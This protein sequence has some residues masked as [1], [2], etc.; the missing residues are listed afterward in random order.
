LV[1]LTLLGTQKGESTY[2]WI[3]ED[4]VGKLYLV[5][6]RE[7]STIILVAIFKSLKEICAYHF[8]VHIKVQNDHSFIFVH[9]IW[10]CTLCELH[11]LVGHK[12]NECMH[13][14]VSHFL[15]LWKLTQI[16][17]RT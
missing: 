16:Y 7:F 5:V 14:I 10:C 3:F 1:I 17:N 12:F 8:I 9:N 4:E 11:T 13:D 6:F 15:I 2:M